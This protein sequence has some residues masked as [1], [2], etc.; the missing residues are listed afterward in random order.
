METTRDPKWL[1]PPGGL[2]L[3]SDEV[4]VWRISPNWP[5]REVQ[6]LQDLLAPDE[7]SRAGRFRS[8]TDRQRFVIARGLLRTI[9]SRYLG[10]EPGQVRFAYD[11]YGKPALIPKSAPGTL[12]FNMSHAHGLSLVAITRERGIGIDVEYTRPPLPDAEQIVERYFSVEEKE[13]F[14]VLPPPQRHEAFFRWWTCKEAY[15][16]ARGTGLSLPLDRLVVALNPGEPAPLLRVKGDP[17]ETGRW[18]FRELIPAP[19]YV[20]TLAVEGA[21]WRLACWH[22][23]RS[24]HHGGFSE[25]FRRL[26][27]GI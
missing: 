26:C 5:A 22:Y 25:G 14:R 6:R 10:L 21:G 2:G 12:N 20:A 18:S 8:Q 3:S 16:K 23:V 27:Q 4:H 9:L 15:L 7:L 24:R 11:D 13:A 1:V 17:Q 19:G